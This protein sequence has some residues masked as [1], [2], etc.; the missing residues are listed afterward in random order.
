[1]E[2]KI[3]QKSVNERRYALQLWS[4]Y[5]EAVVAGKKRDEGNTCTF[6]QQLMKEKT[7]KGNYLQHPNTNKNAHKCVHTKNTKVTT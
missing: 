2:N 3:N 4:D 6:A 1:M 5:N 7:V